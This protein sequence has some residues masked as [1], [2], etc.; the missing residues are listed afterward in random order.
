[1]RPVQIAASCQIQ[2]KDMNGCTVHEALWVR[3]HP[4]SCFKKTLC[5]DVNDVIFACLGH[6]TA[7][8]LQTNFAPLAPPC[9]MSSI[10]V[11]KKGV[12]QVNTPLLQQE[13]LL[14]HQGPYFSCSHPPTFQ[15]RNAPMVCRM[16]NDGSLS[17]CVPS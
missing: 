5:L 4:S 3:L 13:V 8:M 2:S 14:L 12:Q 15:S 9:S 1:M 11:S 10:L 6:I 17:R 7:R 16:V